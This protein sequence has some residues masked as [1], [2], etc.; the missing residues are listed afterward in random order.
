MNP[1]AEAA[2][3]IITSDNFTLW[4]ALAAAFIAGVGYLVNGLLGTKRARP[5]LE[6]FSRAAYWVSLAGLGYAS[7]YLFQCILSS[8]RFDIAYIFNNTA[9]RDELLYRVSAFWAGQQ[10]SL[11]LWALLGG[12]I[13][14][15][16]AARHGKKA[17]LV[18]AFWTA[19]QSFLLIALVADDPFAKLQGFRP[20]VVGVGL[21][22]VLKNPWMA[23][24]PPVI[25][26]GYALLSVP[27]ALAVQALVSRD[28]R[29]WAARCLPWTLAGWAALGAGIMMGMVWSYEVLGW[30]GYWAWDPVENASLIP[31][32]AATALLHGLRA[33]RSRGVLARANIALAFAAFLAV[34][35]ATYL[36][37][38]GVLGE[39]SVHSFEPTK[40]AVLV[41]WFMIGFAIVC[42]GLAAVC[43]PGFRRGEGHSTLK[44]RDIALI[45]GVL[46]LVIFAAVVFAGTS[47]SAFSHGD[48][49]KLLPSFFTRMSRWFA[50]AILALIGFVTIPKWRSRRL[51][52][53]IA[54]A[55][56]LLVVLGIVF[57]SIGG[58][59]VILLDKKGASGSAFGRTIS[60]RGLRSLDDERQSYRLTIRRGGSRVI[61]AGIIERHSEVGSSTTPLIISSLAGDLYISPKDVDMVSVS[62]TLTLRD[63]WQPTPAKLPG[64]DAYLMLD[65]MKIESRE[66]QLYFHAPGREPVEF[67]V[68]PGRPAHIGGYTFTYVDL[69]S[70]GDADAHV[71]GV[72]LALD[73]KLT[74]QVSAKPLIWMLWAGCMLIILGGMVALVR[75]RTK[76]VKW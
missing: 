50:A 25:F 18:A 66:A 4:L 3:H 67:T 47:Y 5:G 14:A 19:I 29:G 39:A 60:Y 49:D 10:G 62:P 23:F 6:R 58:S 75:G 15:A 40:T 71:V 45:L 22:P 54:H 16:L 7:V 8:Q 48:G 2:R 44:T 57:S 33:Q 9:P 42:A 52:G 73:E 12:I 76:S 26:L 36:T 46:I 31:W 64:S 56:V 32:L 37:R 59:E 70:E 38:S 74:L 17:P 24:H 28:I 68:S 1:T 21:N 43:L 53:H 20:D 41:K 61:E 65:G 51:G 55:G 72:K 69:F 13:G 63:S 30:G 11:L 34:L 35:F 27:A